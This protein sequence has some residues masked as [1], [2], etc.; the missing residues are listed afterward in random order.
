MLSRRFNFAVAVAAV[1]LGAQA[2]RAS[3]TDQFGFGAKPISM[4][5][6]FTALATDWTGAYYNPAAPAVGKT[7]TIGAGFSYATYDLTYKS[8][9]G[10]TSSGSDHD[11]ARQA[12]LSALTFG[13]SSPLSTDQSELLSRIVPGIGVFLP[14]R[15]IVGIDVET[16]PGSPQYFLYG[17]RRDKLAV[18]PFV[19]VRILPLD[20]PAGQDGDHPEHPMTLA[21]GGGATILSDISGH[22]TFDLSS[23]AAR[24]VA[25]DIKLA[26]TAAPNFGIYFW[27]LAGLSLGVTYRGKLALKADFDTQ[28]LVGSTNLFPLKIEAVTLFQP[29]QVAAG[30]AFDPVEWLT[31]AL[32]VTW[33]NWSAY[34]DAFVTIRPVI[35]QADVKFSDIVIPRLG[36]E[37]RFDHGFAARAGYYF[38]PS[39]IGAQTGATNLVDNDKHVMSLGFGWTFWTERDRMVRDG[40]G[41]KLV[42][43]EHDPV[44]IDAFFQW[45][46]LLDQSVTKDPGA[47]PQT[48]SFFDSGGDVFN[49]GIQLTIRT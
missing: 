34:N 48:G 16:A 5:N 20:N 15:G 9:T 17:T 4:G 3:D 13:I 8:E 45:H 14:T 33:L 12:P 36:A 24:S 44:S 10:S 38:Q 29:Q 31:L 32:D 39:P 46:H 37:V 35:P 18:M 30:A 2:V 26:Y 41:A 23:T 22:F 47:S 1:V 40:E 42:K 6:A 7:R 43:E 28:I 19:S 21:L 49:F 11:V 25:T 27:P